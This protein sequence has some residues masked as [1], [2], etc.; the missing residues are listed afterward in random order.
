[1]PEENQDLSGY[2]A[3]HLRAVVDPLSEL[4]ALNQPQAFSVRLTDGS[5]ATAAVPLAAEP[6]LAFPYG[7]AVTYEDRPDRLV[8]DN[9]VLLSS[10]RVPL[11]QFAGV[12]L[13][14]IRSIA[15]VFDVTDS[16]TVFLT[17]L[18]LLHA[19]GAE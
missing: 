18:E 1:L 13:T 3:L 11:S 7:T 16:G 6:A 4:N 10:I 5:G 9:N 15:L 17:D 19:Q 12:D 2:Q 8:W 14:D